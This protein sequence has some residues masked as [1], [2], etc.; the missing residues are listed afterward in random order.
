MASARLAVRPWTSAWDGP[1]FDAKDVPGGASVPT[2]QSTTFVATAEFFRTL[3]TGQAALDLQEKYAVT[4]EGNG[5]EGSLT[6]TRRQ[7]FLV[8][9][10]VT[11]PSRRLN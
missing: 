3:R 10:A 2:L 9:R 11:A 8:P 1:G 6:A 7:H 5:L 4:V